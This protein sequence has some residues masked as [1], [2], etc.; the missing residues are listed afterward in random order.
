MNEKRSDLFPYIYRFMLQYNSLHSNF[1]NFLRSVHDMVHHSVVFTFLSF[2]QRS[3]PPEFLPARYHLERTHFITSALAPRS[4]S[5]LALMKIV[6]STIET[7][8]SF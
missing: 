7:S 2:N 5:F 3:P 4:I 6:V 8:A 1:L